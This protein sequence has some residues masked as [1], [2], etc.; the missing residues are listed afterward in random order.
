[1]TTCKYRLNTSDKSSLGI[2]SQQFSIT[3]NAYL[4]QP[5]GQT[6][7]VA[8]FNY[9][10]RIYMLLGEALT[11]IRFDKRSPPQGQFAATRLE[12]MRAL[13]SRLLTCLLH[14]PLMFQLSQVH[15]AS[16]FMTDD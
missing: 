4:H 5:Q 8:G 12:D 10:S 16:R 2:L 3:R 7:L 15:S 11:K 1:M 9:T 14:S 6:A 13:H